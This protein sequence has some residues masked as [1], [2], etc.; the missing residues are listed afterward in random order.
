MAKAHRRPPGRP[1]SVDREAAID[2][3]VDH[4]WRRG[5][6]AVSL[7]ELCRCVGLSKPAVYREFGGEDGLLLASLERYRVQIL[8][9]RQAALTAEVPFGELL[10]RAIVAL[11]TDRGTPPGC[12]FTRL[13]TARARLSPEV[14]ARVQMLEHEQ[15][16]RLGGWYRGALERGEANPDVSPELAARYLDTQFATILTQMVLG[17]P[18]EDVRAEARLAA[19]ALRPPDR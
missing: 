3:A 1:R 16:E 11:T 12:L 2:A 19:V 8:T 17:Q 6:T 10:D 13:R 18:P 14:L 15:L 9:P 4:Y 7:N 5:P